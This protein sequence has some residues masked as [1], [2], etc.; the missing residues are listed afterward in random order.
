MWEDPFEQFKLF[1]P[2]YLT[3]AEGRELFEE[4]KQFPTKQ[5][6]YLADPPEDLLQGDAWRGFVAINFDSLERKTVSGLILSNSCD[7]DV[8]NGRV[9]DMKILFAPLMRLSSYAELLADKGRNSEQIEATLSAIRAQKVTYIFYLPKLGDVIEESMALLDDMHA[10][11]LANFVRRDRVRLFTLSLSGF[12]L[13]LL[14]LSIH[15]S[16]FQEAVRRFPR[17]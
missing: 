10:H 9:V 15:F 2:K 1:L 16:R 11:P 8:H 3:P 17:A 5:N 12:Y 13:L 7:I 4:L 6:F 14:K